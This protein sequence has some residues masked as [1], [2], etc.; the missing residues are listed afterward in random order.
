[1]FPSEWLQQQASQI[2]LHLGKILSQVKMRTN[3]PQK[4]EPNEAQA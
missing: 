4:F 3:C 2:F 1:M